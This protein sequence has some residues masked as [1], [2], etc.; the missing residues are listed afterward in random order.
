MGGDPTLIPDYIAISVVFA[1]RAGLERFPR[2]KQLAL[3]IVA[4]A[5]IFMMARMG[6]HRSAI[7][8]RWG[9]GLPCGGGKAD[10]DHP[11]LIAISIL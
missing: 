7:T 9:K 1:L 11:L 3:P 4:G 5:R 6:Q 2:G 10:I 8:L